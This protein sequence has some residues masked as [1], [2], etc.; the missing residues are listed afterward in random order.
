MTPLKVVLIKPSKYAADGLVERFKTGFMPNATLFHIASLTPETVSNTP[1]TVHTVDEYVLDNLEYL[2]LL[3]KDPDF[4][5]L[6]ALVGVQSHQFHRALD[7]AAYAREHGIRHCVIGGPHVMTCDTSQFQDRGISFALAEAEVV[8][9]EILADAVDGELKPVYGT[10]QRWAPI[11]EGRVVNPPSPEAMKNY[12]SPLMGLYPVRGCPYKCNYCSVIKIAGRPIRS[13]PVASTLESLRRAKAAGV[14]MIM[15]VSDNFNKYPDV[16]EL[17]EA[18][19]EEKLDLPFFCQCDTQVVRQPELIELLGK[20]NCYEILLGIESFN[21]EI[22]RKANKHHNQPSHYKELVN[23][24]HSAGIGAHFSNIIGFPEDT[25]ESIREQLAIINDL[26]PALASFH[27][28]TPMPGTEQY[29]EYR[30]AGLIWE[31]NLDRFGATSLTWSHPVL[32]AEQLS[33]LLYRCYVEFNTSHLKK[34]AFSEETKAIALI[35][36]H[37]AKQGIHPMSGG[38]GKVALDRV[39][40]YLELR[41][42][43]FD[44]ELA[45]LPDNLELSVADE[46]FNNKIELRNIPLVKNPN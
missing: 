39:E 6:V 45:P 25:E 11:L 16:V 37:V 42:R 35:S 29:K 13:V 2:R 34:G 26:N 8:W 41:R 32:S 36:R 15:F 4:I 7:L 19:I 33:H 21:R 30:S 10:D 31:T 20:A 1:V 12:W 5:T 14:K 17:L 9:P 44:I 40:S 27:I 38:T 18:M 22:L 28:L 24:C 46:R 43:C 3:E 23:L